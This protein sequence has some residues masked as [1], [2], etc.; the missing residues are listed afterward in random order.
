[1]ERQE[2]LAA[3]E[4]GEQRAFAAAAGG[5]GQQRQELE[6]AQRAAQARLDALSAERQ[7]L[8]DALPRDMLTVYQRIFQ[9]RGGQA[10]VP[11]EHQAC[12]GCGAPLPLQLVNEIRKMELLFTCET[13]GRILIWRQEQAENSA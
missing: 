11:V 5:I 9:G 12:G 2:T 8:V 3:A 6:Q 1:M 4:Q 10:V 13:C 7:R